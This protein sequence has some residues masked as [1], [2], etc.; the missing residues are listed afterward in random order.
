GYAPKDQVAALRAEVVRTGD[1][2][3]QPAYERKGKDYALLFATSDY[4]DPNWPHLPNPVN[5]AEALK[6]VLETKYGFIVDLRKNQTKREIY[7]TLVEYANKTFGDDDQV[8]IFFAGHGTFDKNLNEG[9]VVAKDSRSKADDPMRDTC[10]RHAY[11]YKLADQI[12]CPHVLV[13]LDVCFGGTFGYTARSGDEYQRAAPLK[14]IAD[15]MKQRCRKWLTSGGEQYVYDGSGD[16]SP[17]AY[18]LLE[19]LRKGGEDGL[20]LFED[21]T[22]AARKVNLNQQPKWGDFPTNVP[23]SDF[24]FIAKS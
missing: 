6:Q 23:G 15:A 19:T 7:D 18:W 1:A 3:P 14:Q 22:R 4:D 12:K 11:I 2:K 16:H 9:F 8:F 5:D 20:V 24:V 17:F 10:L 13:T 21:L